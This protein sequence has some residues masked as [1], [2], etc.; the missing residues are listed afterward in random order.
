MNLV[1]KR[2]SWHQHSLLKL[3]PSIMKFCSAWWHWPPEN[4]ILCNFKSNFTILILMVFHLLH[5]LNKPWLCF[6]SSFFEFSLSCIC[7]SNT[8]LYSVVSLDKVFTLSSAWILSSSKR[9]ILSWR[10]FRAENMAAKYKY[11]YY[12]VTRH[13]LE[14]E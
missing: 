2:N 9:R 13:S 1:S 6:D 7:S 4:A 3:Y 11:G 12:K 5:N 8:F 14:K 10:F